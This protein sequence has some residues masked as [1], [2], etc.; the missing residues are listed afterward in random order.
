[1]CYITYNNRGCER[2]FINNQSTQGHTHTHKQDQNKNR[3]ISSVELRKLIA[4]QMNW[5]TEKKVNYN[6][7]YNKLLNIVFY[8]NQYHM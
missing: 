4:E 7:K 3:K 8:T 5:S 1:M 2:K 6:Y